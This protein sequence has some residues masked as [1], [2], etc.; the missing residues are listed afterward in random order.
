MKSFTVRAAG[1]S[2]SCRLRRS[3]PSPAM[4]QPQ[5]ETEAPTMPKCGVQGKSKAQKTLACTSCNVTDGIKNCI[6]GK[7]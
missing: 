5:P 1:H 7:V 2:D 4:C 3:F 6:V